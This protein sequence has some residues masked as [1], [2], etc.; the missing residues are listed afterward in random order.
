[1]EFEEEK[2][3]RIRKHL[4]KAI[5]VE[6]IDRVAQRHGGREVKRNVH[7]MQQDDLAALQNS[8]FQYLIGNTDFSTRGRHNEKLLYTENKYVS[9]PYDFDMS[10]L[11][12]ASYA[13]ISGM[14]NME[15]SITHVTQRV[16]KGYKRDA[17]LVQK[18]RQDFIAHKD[19]IFRVIDSLEE[20][21]GNQR[22]FI[23]AKDFIAD[24]YNTMEDDKKFRKRIIEGT[25]T[26]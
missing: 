20:F 6:D 14:D 4:L 11:V 5:L 25:R 19:E 18:V 1:M 24:F 26:Y 21:F 23:T 17:R 12:D 13:T 16:Y 9:V 15:R 22:Q 7:P 10:G 3:S 8:F 2:G